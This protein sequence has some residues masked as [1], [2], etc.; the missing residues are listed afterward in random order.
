[1]T[2]PEYPPALVHVASVSPDAAA[3]L[4]P[5]RP[6]HDPGPRSVFDTVVLTADEPVKQLLKPDPNRAWAIIQVFDNTIVLT[7]SKG[8]AQA[9][10]NTGDTTLARPIGAIVPTGVVVPLRQ[11]NEVWAAAATYPT[12][13][14]V[15]SA[16]R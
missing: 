10:A 12:R 2:T 13:I 11:Q 4:R 7:T 3:A 15:I 16:Y 1:M 8:N 5:T 9:A 6:G 14:S